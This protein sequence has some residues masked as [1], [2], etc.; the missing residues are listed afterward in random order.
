[1]IFRSSIP[2]VSSLLIIITACSSSPEVNQC[3]K[4]GRT[5]NM[6][7]DRAPAGDSQIPQVERVVMVVLENTDA[8]KALEQPFLKRLTEGGAYLKDF[9]ATSRPS[10]PNYIV[11]TA[12][13]ALGVDSNN[14]YQLDAKH[15]GDL[16]EE[17]GKTWKVYAEGYPGNCFLGSSNGPYVRKHVPFLSYKNV[18]QD[19]HKCGNIVASTQFATDV[20]A[21]S[22]PNFS[23]FIPDNNSNGHDTG[24]AAA[25]QWMQKTFATLVND[26]AFMEKTLFVVTFDEASHD[27]ESNKIYTLLYGG[28]VAP[29]STHDS[30]LTH[31]NLLRTVEESLG[32]GTLGRNDS[33]AKAI[34]G[35]WKP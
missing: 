13:S 10:Q 35:V 7:V 32:I 31:Y 20:A 8:T 21:H 19:P 30:C 11:L 5:E 16:L 4:L 14:N 22:L 25:D 27:D 24:I 18:Q 34:Q 1:M 29:G 33:E 28:A 12:G 15:L 6:S 2:L 17:K 3:E 26:Q 9:Y 23:L